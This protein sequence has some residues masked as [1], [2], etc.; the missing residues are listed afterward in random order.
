M[1]V[2]VTVQNMTVEAAPVMPL[3]NLSVDG[4]VAA[5]GWR[6]FREQQDDATSRFCK[7]SCDGAATLTGEVDLIRGLHEGH[8]N[9]ILR[10]PGPVNCDALVGPPNLRTSGESAKGGAPQFSLP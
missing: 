4:D 2:G 7:K 3:G 9:S 5:K 10:E 1:Q 6:S 8:G